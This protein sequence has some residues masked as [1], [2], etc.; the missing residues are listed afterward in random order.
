MRPG[1]YT[2]SE[3]ISYLKT[4]KISEEIRNNTFLNTKWEQ[5]LSKC[6]SYVCEFIINNQVSV[7]AVCMILPE[8]DYLIKLWAPTSNCDSNTSLFL[9]EK[10]IDYLE[11][12]TSTR[13]IHYNGDE[14]E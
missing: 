2:L 9:F 8:G 14:C 4:L 1:K 5:S 7:V 13:Y 10:Y 6:Q 11:K 3:L 12:L